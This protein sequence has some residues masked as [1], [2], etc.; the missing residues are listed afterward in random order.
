MS[1]IRSRVSWGFLDQ[2]L[3]SASN[4]ALSGFVAA[5]VSARDFGAFTLV[6][7]IYNLV[8]GF[9]GGLAS[10]PLVVRFSAETPERFRVATKSALGA[11]VT[12]GIIGGA[13]CVVAAPFTTAA[14]A[15]PLVALGVMLP[16]LVLQDAWRY[17]FVTGGR[18]AR[19]A[20]ND[21][22]WVGIQF[23][24]SI[25]LLALGDVTALSMVLLWGGS[26]TAAAALGCWQAKTLPAPRRALT[27]L[28]EQRAITWR[29]AAEALV[30][31]SGAWVAL[32]VV[33]AVAGLRAVGALRGAMLLLG[34]PL[35]LLLMGATFVFVS[36]GVRLLHRAPTQLP[37]AIRT[38]NLA[39]VAAAI[40]WAI[41][42][43]V[44]PDSVGA[45]VLGDTWPDAK[46]LLPLLLVY[47]A[48]LAA[49]LGPTQGIIALGAAKRSLFTQVA[50]FAVQLPL[51]ALGAAVSGARGAAVAVAVAALFRTVLA[52]VQ[53]RRALNESAAFPQAIPA[54]Q[55]FAESM[56]S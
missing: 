23:M 15:E 43:F 46:P 54:E 26:A 7:G 19:A 28:R 17:S 3:S 1:G 38:L 51:M 48:A 25:A 56:T 41:V 34:G 45:R 18:P 10:V 4:F 36:E 11:A 50:A 16:G 31:R 8:V 49:S 52:W 30:H 5:T 24:G 22:A 2:V 37:R 13:L 53:F 40:A 39:A 33:G 9:T 14:V 35:N 27:W 21:G 6:Y 47:I 20:A 44:L 12:V 32:A 29:Y 42:V 55:A